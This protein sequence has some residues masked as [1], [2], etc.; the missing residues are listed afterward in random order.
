MLL[1]LLVLAVLAVAVTALLAVLAVVLLMRERRAGNEHRGGGE[2]EV[3]KCFHLDLLGG[4]MQEGPA[5]AMWL[6]SQCFKGRCCYG[7]CPTVR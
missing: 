2:D 1:I 3:T 4:L 5:A 7:M 6:R